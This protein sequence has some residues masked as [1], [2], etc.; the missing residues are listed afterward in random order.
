M[1][2]SVDLQVELY[3][4]TASFDRAARYR[5]RAVQVGI[6]FGSDRSMMIS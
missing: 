4:L 3:R 2:V 1:L 5:G 6:S